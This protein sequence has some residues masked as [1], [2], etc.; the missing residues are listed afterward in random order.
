[1]TEIVINSNATD[2]TTV[3]NE[4]IEKCSNDG[5]GKVIVSPGKYLTGPIHLKSNVNLHLAD[6]ATILFSDNFEDYRPVWSR[7]EGV[8]CFG[9][10]PCL[11][12][13]GLKNVSITGKGVIDGNGYKWWNEYKRRRQQGSGRLRL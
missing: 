11:Y 7:W 10:C 1:M 12:G 8:E 9:Y 13:E 4:A 6:G 2:Y 3:F 5:G